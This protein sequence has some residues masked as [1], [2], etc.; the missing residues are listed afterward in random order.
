MNFIIKTGNRILQFI[1]Y[2][3]VP[4]FGRLCN[5]KNKYVNVIYYH[6]IVR[7]EGFSYMR[8]NISVFKQQM[9][10]LV[11]KGYETL[12]FDDLDDDSIRFKK[13]RVLIAFDDGWR[14]NY[15]EIYEYMKEKGL[16]YNI[17]LTMGEIGINP[18]YL[19]W[20]MVRE[21]HKSGLCGFGA[22]TFTHPDMSDINKINFN[23]EIKDADALF[24][25]ELGYKPVDFCYPFGYYSEDSNL[26]LERNSDYRH[27]YTSKKMYSYEQ[28]GCVVFG[29]NGISTDY[30]IHY[31]KMK[32]KG[33]TNWHKLYYD[34]FFSHILDFYHRFKHS[35]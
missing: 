17:F 35:K 1:D 10:W 23:H 3:V 28:N 29:R 18:E 22:H 7:D 15:T 34:H 2:Q 19:T 20:D 26:Y 11:S 21:M 14:S 32:A 9:E 16:K 8:T 24:E 27:I 25:K 4:F 33:Y 12:R 31:F 13:G 30:P 5:S 6:D